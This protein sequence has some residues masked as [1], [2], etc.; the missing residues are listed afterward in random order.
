MKKS[1]NN[2]KA[3][4][5]MKDD[6]KKKISNEIESNRSYLKLTET[7]INDKKKN[8]DLR[9]NA[10]GFIHG[11]SSVISENLNESFDNSRMYQKLDKIIEKSVGATKVLKETIENQDYETKLLNL[12]KDA[13]R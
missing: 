10:S 7:S 5:S 2:L 13:G 9:S 12:L 6:K 1:N 8:F 4:P 3:N 11:K